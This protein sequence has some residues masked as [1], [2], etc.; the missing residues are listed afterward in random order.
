MSTQSK[1][2]DLQNMVEA[3]SPA[4]VGRRIHIA[5][6]Q[7][8]VDELKNTPGATPADV[9]FAEKVWAPQQEKERADFG[10]QWA[11]QTKARNEARSRDVSADMAE[12]RNEMFRLTQTIASG[13]VAGSTDLIKQAKVYRDRITAYEHAIAE[14]ET[15]EEMVAELE[16]APESHF[17]SFYAKYPSLAERIPTLTDALIAR[18]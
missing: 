8:Q 7:A 4:L 17:Y 1:S 14:L 2:Y 10:M 11:R 9:E 3:Q 16:A 6:P 12:D 5:T 18:R 15:A 13:E